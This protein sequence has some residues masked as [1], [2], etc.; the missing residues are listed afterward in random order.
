MD[1]LRLGVQDQPGHHGETPSLKKKKK[2]WVGQKVLLLFREVTIICTYT[3]Y[4]RRNG[5]WQKPG[6]SQL[7]MVHMGD[8]GRI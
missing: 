5:Y 2:W 1:H 8:E 3:E 7:W 4:K 6:E